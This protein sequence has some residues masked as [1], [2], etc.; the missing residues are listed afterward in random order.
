MAQQ[1]ISVFVSARTPASDLDGEEEK[2]YI[3]QGGLGV[4]AK[5]NQI[6]ASVLNT[7]TDS[8]TPVLSD[9]FKT[10]IMNKATAT[11]LT[12]P[13]N[14]SVA[15]NINTV[16][17]FRRTGAGVMSFVAGAGVTLVTSSGGL[18]DSG[19]NTLMSATKNGTNTWNIDNGLTVNITSADVTGALGYTP[20]T[21]ARTIA[22]L[23]LTTNRTIS[24]LIDAIGAWHTNVLSSDQSTTSASLADCGDL[25]FTVVANTWYAFK[26]RIQYTSAVATTGAG[27]AINGPTLTSMDYHLANAN[28]VTA[29]SDNFR[30][31]YDAFTVSTASPAQLTGYDELGGVIKCSAGGDVQLRFAT[32]VGGSAIGVL[33]DS[34]FVEFKKIIAK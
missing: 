14:S 18:T 17:F 9:A 34:S 22:G 2:L 8:Y 7:Q 12:I 29:E 11:N 1:D 16:I 26:F 4:S 3:V 27:F 6:R 15:Y 10:I 23:D 33:K 32:E 31:A 24:E 30:G 21:N 13:P 28:S 5:P 25:K 19:Q 20:V